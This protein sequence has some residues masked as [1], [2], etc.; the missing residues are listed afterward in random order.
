MNT[1]PTLIRKFSSN[2]SDEHSRETVQHARRANGSILLNKIFTFDS[3]TFSRE[4]DKAP[5]SDRDDIEEF[6]KENKD[7]IFLWYNDDDEITY[8]VVFV[9]PP[10]YRF[11]MRSLG[12]SYWN[13][14]LTFEQ[15]NS[16][17]Y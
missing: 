16:N 15:E 1:F 13:I 12:E 8:E 17:T 11:A 2:L 9:Q 14:S 5:Q 7:E 10:K 3:M 6:Y 4:L